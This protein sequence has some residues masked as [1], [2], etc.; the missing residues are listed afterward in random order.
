MSDDDDPIGDVVCLGV[1]LAGT[2]DNVVA[3]FDAIR[4]AVNLT[5]PATWSEVALDQRAPDDDGP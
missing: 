5:L 1:L 4:H 2:Q 3:T